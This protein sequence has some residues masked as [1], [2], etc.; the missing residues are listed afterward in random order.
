MK[1]E[2]MDITT[3]ERGLIVQGVNCRH[4]MGAGV[5]L[6][7]MEKWPIVRTSYMKS[8]SGEDMLG[9]T[10]IINVEP[11][12][13]V[14]NCYTQL[15]YIGYSGHPSVK[16]CAS[17]DAIKSSLESAFIHAEMY[18]IPIYLPQIG[19]GLGGLDWELDVEP[20]IHSLDEQYE[21]V[22]TTICVWR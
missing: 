1:Y 9:T 22:E 8:S 10:H 20:I 12:I 6:A 4:A 7:I 18:D 14:A 16:P 19:A 21:T 11:G 13:S 2:N 3:V 5:A 15:D 17:V